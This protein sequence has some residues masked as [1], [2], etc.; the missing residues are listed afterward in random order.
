MRQD[1]KRQRQVT[2]EQQ[3]QQRRL[4]E[5]KLTMQRNI[6]I[7]NATGSPQSYALFSAPPT[8]TPEARSM[9]SSFILVLR[10][11]A[12]ATGQAFFTLP[13]EPLYAVCGV[14]Y[15]GESTVEMQLDVLDTR[16]IQLGRTA[17]DSSLVP[18]TTLDLIIRRQTPTFANRPDIPPSAK[19]GCFCIRTSSEFSHN[20]AR[21]D[22]YVVGVSLFKKLSRHFG[23]YT[24]FRPAPGMEYQV[25]PSNKFYLAIGDYNMR[26]RVPDGLDKRSLL[27]DFDVLELDDVQVYHNEQ[28]RLT[29]R[30]DFNED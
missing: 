30:S 19:K 27:I 1:D 22:D 7:T 16:L 18:G 23:P 12:S 20:E 25:Q 11:L 2:P 29:V 24:T 14:M 15:S 3:P 6:T 26:S 10:G 13:K 17:D 9:R 28:G 21:A 4:Q 5:A 8:V